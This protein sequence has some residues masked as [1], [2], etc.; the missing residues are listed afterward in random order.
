MDAPK[1]LL[2]YATRISG[3]FL[4]FFACARKK[5]YIIFFKIQHGDDR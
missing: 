3:I 2:I 5:M 4:L 1:G